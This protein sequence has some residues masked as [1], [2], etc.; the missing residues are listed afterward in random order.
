MD[1]G[2]Q[3]VFDEL[4]ERAREKEEKEAKKR[5]RLGDDFFN[6]L[7]SFKVCYVVCSVSVHILVTED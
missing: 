4:L 2:L 1:Y 7:C 3:L 6:L 5:K